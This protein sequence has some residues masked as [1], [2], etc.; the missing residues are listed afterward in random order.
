MRAPG[1]SMAFVHSRQETYHIIYFILANGMRLY[2]VPVSH[3]FITN[4]PVRNSP[5]IRVVTHL[6]YESA[7]FYA[8]V[9]TA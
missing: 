3:V 7:R 6:N 8:R 5:E 2:S 9:T 1:W 4:I